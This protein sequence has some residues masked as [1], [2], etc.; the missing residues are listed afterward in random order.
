MGRD[1]PQILVSGLGAGHTIS[2]TRGGEGGAFTAPNATNPQPL[3][4]ATAGTADS[5][6]QFTFKA[7]TGPWTQ[8]T[9]TAH[10]TGGTAYTD[11]TATLFKN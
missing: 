10:V 9:L 8:D 5:T 3:T 6:T 11:A 7:Q 1:V 4:I 2:V